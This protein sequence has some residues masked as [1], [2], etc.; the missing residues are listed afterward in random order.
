VPPARG[1]DSAELGQRLT[2]A[3]L[4][5]AGGNPF[6]AREVIQFWDRS[7]GEKQLPSSVARAVTDQ[8]S[9]LGEATTRVIQV[10]ALLGSIATLRRVTRIM[11]C[12]VSELLQA[13][14][15]L[16]SIGIVS[17]ADDDA[18]MTVH[19][20]WREEVLLSIRPIVRRCC[21]RGLR[22]WLRR[23]LRAFERLLSFGR[24]RRIAAIRG[25]QRL[26]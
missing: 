11:D 24:L 17:L 5:I 4:Q 1:I 12:H 13:F 6:F 18:V 15:E 25:H 3:C 9:R 26:Q 8:V 16:D 23:R 7:G 20:I 19:D 14:E 22:M 2:V 21:M 10:I